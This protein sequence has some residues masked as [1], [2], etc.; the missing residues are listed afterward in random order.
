MINGL[1]G[2]VN[3]ATLA[4][5]SVASSRREREA[6]LPGQATPSSL[7]KHDRFRYIRTE[8]HFDAWIIG[9]DTPSRVF[10][11]RTRAFVDRHLI[12][13]R[14][15]PFRSPSRSLLRQVKESV[16]SYRSNPLFNPRVER[17][18]GGTVSSNYAPSCFRRGGCASLSSTC[19]IC[20]F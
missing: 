5:T 1:T 19:G 2:A 11:A 4:L 15:V 14:S 8:L 13:W 6:S 7:G 20:V 3:R 17:P 16:S 18:I 12:T 9:A 10:S